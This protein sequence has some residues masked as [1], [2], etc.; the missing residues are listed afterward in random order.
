M[1]IFRLGAKPLSLKIERIRYLNCILI[2]FFLMQVSAC[3]RHPSEK[4]Q[5]YIEGRYTYMAT[6][7]SG[8][9]KE[10]YVERGMRVQQGQKLF[11]LEAEPESDLYAAAMENLKQSINARDVIA[12]NLTYAKVTYERYKILVPK[13]AIQQS[14]LDSAKANYNAILAQLAQ[15]NA[16]IASTSATLAQARWT[17]NQKVVTAPVDAFVFDTYYRLGEYTI[18]D[19][20]VLSLL[21][22][23]DIKAIFYIG[24]EYLSRIHLNDQVQVQC[25]GCR[26]AYPAHISFISPS[27]E[28][29]PP[30]IYSNETNNKLIY[31]IEAEFKPQDAFN[32]HPGQPVYVTYYLQP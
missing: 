12:A 7:V 28:Y 9:L 20:A 3:S 32:M 22:P 24:E 21:A 14:E 18:A 27:A 15:A 2:I 25:D 26:N 29:T 10:L 16:N 8:V 6:P 19:Q 23:T 5:G 17:K 11:E 4:A 30:V 13:N 1:Y 31:R